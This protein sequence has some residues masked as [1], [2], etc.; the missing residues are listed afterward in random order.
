MFKGVLTAII[1]PFKDNKID[2][3]ALEILIEK[4]ISAGVS[5]F[6]VLGTTAETPSLSEQE[7]EDLIKFC[8]QRINKR[9]K[10]IVGTGSNNTQAMLKNCEV[11]CKYNPDGLL[12]VTPYY[13]KPNL[14]GMIAHYTLASQFNKPIVLY[15][16][17]GRTGQKL[18]IKFFEELLNNV[19]QIMAVKESCYD[20]AH[21]MDMSVKFGQK[22]INYI[23]GNDDLWPVFLGLGSRAIISAAA[24]TMAPFFVKVYNLF[25]EGKTQEAMALFFLGYSLIKASYV[26]VNPTCVKYLLSLMKLASDEVRLPLGSISE[27][28]KKMLNQIYEQTPQ[29]I[30]L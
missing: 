26:E 28:N 6:V 21:L 13:N 18:S 14:S 19:P 4:Q 30:L 25:C 23:C 9:A 5:G 15:H 11:A 12:I 17:P 2:F 8:T 29:G 16:I 24:N 7:K 22:R 10:I 20:I 1:T 3:H 27:E